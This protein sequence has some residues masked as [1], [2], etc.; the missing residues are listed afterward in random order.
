MKQATTENIYRLPLVLAPQPEGGWTITCPVLPG[1]ITEADTMDEV[2]PNVTDALEALI[3]LYEDLKQPLPKVLL[4]VEQAEP[5][6]GDT[7]IKLAA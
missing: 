6:Y 7:F 2:V 5:M 3:E 1:L 4:P